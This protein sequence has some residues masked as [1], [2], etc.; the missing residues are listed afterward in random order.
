MMSKRS[1]EK[2]E[3]NLVKYSDLG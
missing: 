1:L 2:F 3:F